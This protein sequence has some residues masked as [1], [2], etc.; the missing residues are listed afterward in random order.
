MNEKNQPLPS[1]RFYAFDAGL[2][3]N[4]QRVS[5]YCS[6]RKICWCHPGGCGFLLEP[7]QAAE[8]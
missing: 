4:V 5:Y 2:H 8:R 7:L 6:Q 3:V 1:E